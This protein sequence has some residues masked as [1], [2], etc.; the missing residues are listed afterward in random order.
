MKARP[1]GRVTR[2]QGCLASGAGLYRRRPEDVRLGFSVWSFSC[3]LNVQLFSGRSS[4][5]AA[6]SA[7][8]ATAAST[9][10]CQSKRQVCRIPSPPPRKNCSLS[11]QASP[12]FMSKGHVQM[13]FIAQ[14]RPESHPS[15]A[16]P[17]LA[18]ASPYSTTSYRCKALGTHHLSKL[19][20]MPASAGRMP[21]K[22]RCTTGRA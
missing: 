13:D 17:P 9:A 5:L 22:R 14:T 20:M 19:Y 15:P 18:G 10:V 7:S 21:M 1:H 3:R 16:R 6:T 4:A 2:C 11:V 8:Q 12:S